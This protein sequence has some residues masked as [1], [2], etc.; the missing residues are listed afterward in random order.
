[1]VPSDSHRRRPAPRRS[2]PV[3]HPS[4]PAPGSPPGE[5]PS[6]PSF[7]LSSPPGLVSFVGRV[8]SRRIGVSPP[9]IGDRLNTSRHSF[10]VIAPR[11]TIATS[12]SFVLTLAYCKRLD[13]N[14]ITL[15]CPIS[16]SL[17]SLVVN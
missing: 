3:H 7:P 8:S 14:T 2:F 4:A 11:S 6:A 15:P 17:N 1:T 10:G 16:R 12:A 9:S 13:S 5:S